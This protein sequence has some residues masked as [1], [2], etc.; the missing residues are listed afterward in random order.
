MKVEEYSKSVEFPKE[1]DF[2][3]KDTPERIIVEN[4]KAGFK[5]R[6]PKGW[7]VEKVNIDWE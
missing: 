4:K 5:A 2:I 1:R 6:A 7:K 3:I